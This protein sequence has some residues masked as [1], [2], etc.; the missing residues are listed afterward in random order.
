MSW[1]FSTEPEFVRKLDGMRRVVSE[2]C[3]RVLKGN[4]PD[5]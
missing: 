5:A 2:Q 4:V 3:T 1:D